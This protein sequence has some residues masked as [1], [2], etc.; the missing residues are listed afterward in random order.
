MADQQLDT[1]HLDTRDA[2][3]S[4]PG[5]RPEIVHIPLWV[6]AML[7]TAG[8]LFILQFRDFRSSLNDAVLKNRAEVAEA[9]ANYT[10]AIEL[11]KDLRS[12]YPSDKYLIK[13]LGLAYYHAHNFEKASTTFE[14]ITGAEFSK[15][16][17]DEVNRVL[18]DINSKQPSNFD[19]R[20]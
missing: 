6:K 20:S 18:S 15:K 17:A 8:L 7:T 3:L 11:Y 13:R 19:D 9:R 12:R 16:E 5:T 14:L 4:N 10:D 1:R 2:N